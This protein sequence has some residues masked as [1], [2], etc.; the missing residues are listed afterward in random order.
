MNVISQIKQRIS[1]GTLFLSI[2]I[3]QQKEFTVI[4]VKMVRY[5]PNVFIALS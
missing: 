1:L 2:F 3:E 5:S 4:A